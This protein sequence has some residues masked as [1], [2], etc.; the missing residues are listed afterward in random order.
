MIAARLPFIAVAL[1]CAVLGVWLAGASGDEARLQ[2][3]G[4]DVAAGRSAEALA[5]L[6]GL[7][8]DAADR[9][10][11]VRG[12]AQLG[13]GRLKRARSDLRAAVQRDPNNW[14]LQRDYAVVLLRVGERARARA[15]MSRALALNPRMALP[16]GFAP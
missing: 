13:A 16:P 9:A 5:E 14:L 10:A 11:A 1:A 12:Y 15:R 2:R 3:A 4:D 7:D 8:G 6:D